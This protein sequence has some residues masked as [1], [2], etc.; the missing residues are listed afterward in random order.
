[1]KFPFKLLEN[2]RFD[3]VGFGTNAVDYLI[4]VPE[5]PSFNSKVELDDYVQAPGG[6]VASTIAGLQRLGLATAYAG[7]F[8]DDA[9]G[10]L[11]YSSLE[12]EG[13][14]L[15]FSERIKGA[16]TQIAFIVIDTRN[17]ERTVIWKRDEKLK[18]SKAEAPLEAATKARVVHMTPHD[19]AACIEMARAARSAGAI[20]SIDIDR[21]FDGI[22]DLLPLVDI[23]VASSDIPAMLTGIPDAG[24]SLIRLQELYGNTIVGVTL[25]DEGSLVLGP[26]G[27]I[28][29]R[30]YPVPGGCKD[31]TG[32]GDSF[33]VGLL[34]GILSGQSIEE[35]CRLANAV[36]ALKCRSV[37]AR[38]SLP[39]ESEL[40][41]FVAAE[42]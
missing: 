23:L 28:E 19:T 4:Q 3:V 42:T 5:Y 36:A 38:T 29:T 22:E 27:L 12:D 30:A 20:V 40:L 39:M 10:D 25:G 17:G 6:E 16:R 2:K 34:Y 21:R 31:T 24:R 11:G 37:G 32:A 41:E 26:K 8:G 7:R 15:V 9:A 33:R 14:D 18:Y 13:V 35:S 1:M